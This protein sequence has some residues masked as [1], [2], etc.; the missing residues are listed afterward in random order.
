MK[1]PRVKLA[2]TSYRRPGHEDCLICRAGSQKR[3]APEPAGELRVRTR[4]AGLKGFTADRDIKADPK[5]RKI[6]GAV[7]SSSPHG[8][9]PTGKHRGRGQARETGYEG[10]R[11]AYEGRH[12]PYEARHRSEDR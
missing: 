1:I 12:R 10:R 2:H 4:S 9:A 5:P 3:H 11:R 8:Y 6:A 7:S